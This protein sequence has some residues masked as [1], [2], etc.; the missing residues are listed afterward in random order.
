MAKNDREDWREVVRK[1]L[2]PG[3][4]VPEDEDDLDY[5]I[6]I[7]YSGPPVSYELPRIDPLDVNSGSIPTASVVDESY[8]DSRNLVSRDVP[9]VI[10]PIALPVS[11]IAGVTTSDTQSHR[12][13][14]S[15]DSEVSVL[16]NA[17]SSSASP[18]VS[19]SPV[20]QQSV[21]E[22]RRIPVVTF[23]TVDRSK[24]K[25]LDVKEANSK[26]INPKFNSNSSTLATDPL[27][28]L[29]ILGHNCD[30]LC[31]NR[32]QVSVFKQSN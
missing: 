30:T 15:S 26:H 12:M 32:T 25:E 31:V 2:P 9:P 5:S 7:E 4:F 17:D 27:R 19:P 8:R 3:A 18:S 6:A 24:S 11:Y 28:K 1:M 16:Q 10:E 21:N 14:G 13:S 22:V 20:R 29:N 23:N